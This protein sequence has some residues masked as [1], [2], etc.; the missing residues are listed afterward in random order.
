MLLGWADQ[1]A[2]W[3]RQIFKLWLLPKEMCCK[4]SAFTFNLQ[5]CSVNILARLLTKQKT[6]VDARWCCNADFLTTVLTL[7]NTCGAQPHRDSRDRVFSAVICCLISQ[8]LQARGFEGSG[9]KLSVEHLSLVF[10]VVCDR[11]FITIH[12]ERHRGHS[13]HLWCGI[14][15]RQQAVCVTDKSLQEATPLSGNFGNEKCCF[16]RFHCVLVD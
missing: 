3:K 12:F 10:L 11:L 13:V 2:S 8:I 16:F 9:A 14:L 1:E 5:T 7:S 4:A 6:C 15:Q